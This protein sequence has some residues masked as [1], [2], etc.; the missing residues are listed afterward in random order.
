MHEH[1][2]HACLSCLGAQ[3]CQVGRTHSCRVGR[4]RLKAPCKRGRGNQATPKTINFASA[5]YPDG[6]GVNII[7]C[8]FLNGFSSWRNDGR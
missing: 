3:A 7:V 6:G 4:R 1:R 2:D 8:S 5:V